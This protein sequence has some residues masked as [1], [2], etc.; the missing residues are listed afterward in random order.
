MRYYYKEKNKE[1]EKLFI[2]CVKN[3]RD[4]KNEKI[5]GSSV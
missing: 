1:I 4:K 2:E 3:Q 5:S